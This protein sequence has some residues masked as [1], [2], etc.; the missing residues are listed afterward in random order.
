MPCNIP[1]TIIAA[2]L[3]VLGLATTATANNSIHLSLND[4]SVELGYAHTL[5]QDQWGRTVFTARALRNEDKDTNLGSAGI[6]ALAAIYNVRGLEVGAGL[7]GYLAEN[8]DDDIAST[9]L[10]VMANYFP[11]AL[12]GFGLSASFF[13][14]P[15]I[16]TGLDGEKIKEG[17]IKAAFRIQHRAE[18]FVHYSNIRAEFDNR[19]TETTL[20]ETVR[21][22]VGLNF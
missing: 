22:G 5:S 2:L 6:H 14:G 12:G 15:E 13:Y 19:R 21:V 9:A 8:Y 11:P 18:I 7:R 16:L 20:D 10:G 1:K 17:N 4:D 3:I